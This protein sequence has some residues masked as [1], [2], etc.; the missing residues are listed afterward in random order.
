MRFFILFN[1]FP[2]FALKILN[3]LY[4]KRQKFIRKKKW[5]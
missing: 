2:N 3:K 5:F 1:E 4:G